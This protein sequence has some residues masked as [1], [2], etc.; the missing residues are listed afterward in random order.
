MVFFW[1]VNF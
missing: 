1:A